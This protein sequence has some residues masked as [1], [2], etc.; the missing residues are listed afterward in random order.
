M[1]LVPCG[2]SRQAVRLITRATTTTTHGQYEVEIGCFFL[3]FLSSALCGFAC[4]FTTLGVYQPQ[5]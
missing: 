3:V 4:A 1:P 5:R 2:T